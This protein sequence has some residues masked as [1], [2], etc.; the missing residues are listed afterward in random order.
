MKPQYWPLRYFWICLQMNKFGIKFCYKTEFN[1]YILKNTSRII[2][3]H[4]GK[5][6]PKMLIKKTAQFPLVA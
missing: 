5:C 3:M 6:Q 1:I 2:T 4:H